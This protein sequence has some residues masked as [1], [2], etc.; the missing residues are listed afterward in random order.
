MSTS[1]AAPAT[2]G[3]A[4]ATSARLLAALAAET[5]K[6]PLATISSPA[7]PRRSTSSPLT[8]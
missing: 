3:H 2:C 6:T 4:A 8:P 7:G 5:R 1:R